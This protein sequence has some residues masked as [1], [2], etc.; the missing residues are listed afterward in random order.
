[1]PGSTTPGLSTLLP[2][3]RKGAI[4]A[5][6]AMGVTLLAGTIVFILSNL[7]R[8]IIQTYLIRRHVRRPGPPL[9]DAL[10]TP[11]ASMV[12][13]GVGQ[14]GPEPLE[15]INDI[16]A[17]E[18]PTQPRAPLMDFVPPVSL[19]ERGEILEVPSPGR[20]QAWTDE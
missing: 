16:D 15:G 2:P 6:V 17:A 13:V 12:D 5:I 8:P 1:M 18:G 14:D 19:L 20:R 9:Q 10:P 3:V 7:L 11:T 4:P